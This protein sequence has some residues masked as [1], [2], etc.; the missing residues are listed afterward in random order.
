MSEQTA[1]DRQDETRSR[2]VDAA[3]LLLRE[4]GSAA[5][6]T[7]AV[8]E[9]AGVQAPAIYRLFGDKDGLL[10][11]VAD[12]AMTR[13]VS[14]KAEVVREA[15]REGRDP[16]DDLRDGW[17]VMVDFGLA[18]PEL[19]ARMSDPERVP[20]S[21]ATRAGQEVLAAR[22]RRVAA[23]GRLRVGERRAVDLV[24]AAGTGAILTLLAAPPQERDRA[25]ARDM[26]EAVLRQILSDVA[27]PADAEVATYAIALR[28]HAPTLAT[29]T[30][31]EQALLVEWMDRV[32][33]SAGAGG[34]PVSRGSN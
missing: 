34:T 1:R 11:A 13:F 5:V 6:T 33:R 31:S 2:I 23:S 25:L 3:A 9:R 30:A 14:A 18:N 19:Y 8:A 16:V 20:R 15:E 32:V 28:A 29:L 4:H 17:D 22:I 21:P 12:S 10:D 24:H 27:G 7:R 26:L